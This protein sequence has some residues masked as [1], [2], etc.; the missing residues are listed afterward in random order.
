MLDLRIT[1]NCEITVFH[2]KNDNTREFFLQIKKRRWRAA[3]YSFTVEQL[4]TQTNR[5]SVAIVAVVGAVVV[6]LIR[7]EASVVCE[8]LRFLLTRPQVEKGL[9][10]T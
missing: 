2:K 1:G 9:W 6:R 5:I 8:A 4:I 3:F 10:K 7:A